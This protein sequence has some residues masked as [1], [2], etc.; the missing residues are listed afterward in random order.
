MGTGGMNKVNAAP[1]FWMPMKGTVTSH[2][3]SRINPVTGKSEMHEGIDLAS[4]NRTEPIYASESGTIK[5]VGFNNVLGNFVTI[6]HGEG[7]ETR[8]QH[9]SSITVKNGEV[10]RKGQQI[11]NQGTTGQVTGAHLHFVLFIGGKH[12]NPWP[13]IANKPLAS[14]AKQSLSDGAYVRV[15]DNGEIYVIV[16]GARVYVSSWNN[17]DGMK[18]YTDI[19]RTQLDGLKKYPID[20]TYVLSTDG[21]IYIFAGG[22]PIAVSNWSNV[23]P[24]VNGYTKVDKVALDKA[25]EAGPWSHVRKTPTDGTYVLS[26]DGT[27]YI[28]AGGAPIAVSTW[29][30][31]DPAVN[32]YTKVDKVAL[33]KA[34]EPGPWSHVRKTPADGTYVLSTDG[35][36]YIFAGGAPIAVS[37][38]NN[39]NPAVNGY[40]KVD[41]VAL[42]KAGESGP[43]SHVRKTPEDGTYVLSTDGTIYIFA[44]GAAFA[45]TGWNN[46]NPAVNGYT[47]IDKV[48]LAK[49]DP[50]RTSKK[51]Q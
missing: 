22:A 51:W 23:N 17:V 21:T 10:V 30:N 50:G 49:A 15:T 12:T 3:G 5:A 24:A 47:K 44:G 31:V 46:V 42:A 25:G 8:S 13:Y 11:G 36:I 34:G 48:A 40:T 45:V 32:G 27:I 35:T 18:N 20:G 9:M 28:F 19:S 43:W 38:W 29:D 33:D 7:Y 16:G 37:T 2:Y 4:V 14:T 1:D 6:N 39:V 41:K 26:T